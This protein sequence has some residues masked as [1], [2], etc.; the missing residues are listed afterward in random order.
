VGFSAGETIRCA[1]RVGTEIMGQHDQFGTLET[2]KLA[3]VLVVD[4][5]VLSHIALLEDRSRFV[6]VLQGGVLKAGQLLRP[7]N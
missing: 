5:D 1:T 3:D 6:A 4:G 7:T 2:G